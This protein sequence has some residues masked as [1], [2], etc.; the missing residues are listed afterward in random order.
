MLIVAL[1]PK[2]TFWR[3]W[4]SGDLSR[5]WRWR[6]RLGGGVGER[7]LNWVKSTR[8]AWNCQTYIRA[9]SRSS[10]FIKNE[11][12][13]QNIL[14]TFLRITFTKYI[15]GHKHHNK[16]RGCPTNKR[17]VWPW[18][19]APLVIIRVGLY[20]LNDNLKTQFSLYP[21]LLPSQ[22]F[23]TDRLLSR[24]RHFT[25]YRPDLTEHFY[26][27]YVTILLIAFY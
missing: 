7:D 8:L 15:I 6:R 9:V 11:S 19:K 17:H 5:C 22:V 10:I 2:V 4:S 16:I 1:P 24:C 27:I 21:L 23:L 25:L 26:N 14:C 20:L 13:K 18:A 12:K 3:S